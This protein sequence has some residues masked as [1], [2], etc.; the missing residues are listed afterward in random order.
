MRWRWKRTATAFLSNT[1]VA[2]TRPNMRQPSSLITPG[3]ALI[4]PHLV[5]I[6]L[7]HCP[8]HDV[9]TLL[10][11][12]DRTRPML[13]LAAVSTSPSIRRLTGKVE[14]LGFLCRL[15]HQWNHPTHQPFPRPS[16]LQNKIDGVQSQLHFIPIVI[17][18]S[19]YAPP[20]SGTTKSSFH[21]FVFLFE[22]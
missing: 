15:G 3:Q 7:T 16:R 17:P 6:T 9:M 5:I 2:T 13:L 10:R 8:L 1:K 14:S 21:L 18:L 11:S 12:G 22:S 20:T 4:H 19:V